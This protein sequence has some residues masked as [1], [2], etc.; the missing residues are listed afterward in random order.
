MVVLFAVGLC[1]V[2]SAEASGNPHFANLGIDQAAGP[3]QAGG[4]MEGK[5][6]RFGIAE[7]ALFANVTTASSDGAVNAMHDSFT[8]LGGGMLIANMMME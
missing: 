8:P 5:E 4:N 2:Y 7:S 3:I 6:V 1:V